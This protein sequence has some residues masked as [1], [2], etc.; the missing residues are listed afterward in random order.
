MHR[1][2]PVAAAAAIVTALLLQATLVGPLTT[3][4][5]GPVATGLPAVLVAAVALVDGPGAGMSLGF[6]AGLIADLGSD[7][8][9]GVL[10]LGWLGLG[11]LAGVLGERRRLVADVLTITLTCAAAAGVT[12][13][14]L[15]AVHADG[16]AVGFALRTLPAA[17]LVA[18]LLAVPVLPLV[19]AAL[20]SPTLRPPH[21]VPPDLLVGRSDG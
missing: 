21:P 9:A 16:A 10:A 2:R 3:A 8:P 4:V 1:V 6:A 20:R 13:L 14:L 12:S 5:L 11:L 18:G 15:V 19:R 17:A 7:H